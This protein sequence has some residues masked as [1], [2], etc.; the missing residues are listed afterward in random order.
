MLHKLW[1]VQNSSQI[2]IRSNLQLHNCIDDTRHDDSFKGLD[3]I[4]DISFKLVETKWYKV[5]N[6]VYELLKLVLLL[7][8]ATTS[9]K[10]VFSAMILVQTKLRNKM[11][12]RQSSHFD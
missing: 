9:D 6:M 8:M 3:N 10:T 12:D 7:P 4:V 11:E 1:S 5:Y 2:I